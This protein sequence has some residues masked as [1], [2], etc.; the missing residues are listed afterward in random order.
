MHFVQPLAFLFVLLQQVECRKSDTPTISKRQYE[1]YIA[2]QGKPFK[3]ED[4]VSD[5]YANK[6]N[7]KKRTIW[8]GP[9]TITGGN[10]SYHLD[11]L[12]DCD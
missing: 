6:P 3:V 4:S 8:Y 2:A 10:V 9:Y 12:V 5:Y 11:F 7:A 1:E